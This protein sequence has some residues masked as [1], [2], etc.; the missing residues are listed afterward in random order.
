MGWTPTPDLAGLFGWQCERVFFRACVLSPS[1]WTVLF[2]RVVLSLSIR[3][4]RFAH[5]ISTEIWTTT[6]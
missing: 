3:K 4:K 2:S 6:P 1:G 5:H